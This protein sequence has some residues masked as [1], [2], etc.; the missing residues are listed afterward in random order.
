M[1]KYAIS[2]GYYAGS[3]GYAEFPEGKTWDDV[4]DWS[5][6]WDTLHVRFK[7]SEA[8][9][10]FELDSSTEDVID[11]KRPMSA[12]V[13]PATEDGEVDYNK[14]LDGFEQ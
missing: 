10:E 4:F 2:A 7:D 12:S 11:W 13:H 1:A 3:V 9:V 8:W 5:I 14:E 6:K